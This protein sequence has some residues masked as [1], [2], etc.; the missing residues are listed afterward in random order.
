MVTVNEDK[1]SAAQEQE[2]IA[3]VGMLAGGLVG[4]AV[5]SAGYTR[6]ECDQ[7]PSLAPRPAERRQQPDQ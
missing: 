3:G 7:A 2:W 4:A 1:A 5:H 6:L